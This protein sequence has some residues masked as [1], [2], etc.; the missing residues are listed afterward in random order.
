MPRDGIVGAKSRSE[1]FEMTP[2]MTMDV[3]FVVG[4]PEWMDRASKALVIASRAAKAVSGQAV[5][6]FRMLSLA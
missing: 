5:V 6:H 4:N 2:S 3:G 1:V